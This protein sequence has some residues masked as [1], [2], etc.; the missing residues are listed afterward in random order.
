VNVVY[1]GKEEKPSVYDLTI[2]WTKLGA[3]QQLAIRVAPRAECKGEIDASGAYILNLTSGRLPPGRAVGYL[4]LHHF[5]LEIIQHFKP[6]PNI[7]LGTPVSTEALD[8]AEKRGD[9]GLTRERAAVH[10]Y[11]QC[12]FNMKTNDSAITSRVTAIHLRDVTKA[13]IA[14]RWQHFVPIKL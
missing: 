7:G 5:A 3:K 9:T 10:T 14:G 13:K 8:S 1:T 6:V 12:G 4:M 2:T 11:E